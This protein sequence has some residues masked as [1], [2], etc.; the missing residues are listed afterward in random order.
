MNS[1]NPAYHGGPAAVPHDDLDPEQ[2]IDHVFHDLTV[3]EIKI[4]RWL[5]A[6]DFVDVRVRLLPRR[7]P[8]WWECLM[9]RAEN[10]KSPT[11]GAVQSLVGLLAEELG[12]QFL[13]NEFCAVVWGDRICAHFRLIPQATQP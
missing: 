6:K 2:F 8:G 4:R 5:E 9:L 12:C 10:E 13:P 11:C 1:P 7:G 3:R